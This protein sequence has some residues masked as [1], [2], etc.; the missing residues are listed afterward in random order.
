MLAGDTINA[1][2][3]W[4]VYLAL[5]CSGLIKP[6]TILGG[7]ITTLEEVFNVKTTSYVF[8]RI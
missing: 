7:K 2:Y 8:N 1:T 3:V 5:L 4:L 6:D